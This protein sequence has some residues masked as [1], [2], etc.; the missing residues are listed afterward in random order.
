MM[1]D[2]VICCRMLTENLWYHLEQISVTPS[3]TK[4]FY[5]VKVLAPLKRVIGLIGRNSPGSMRE[6]PKMECAA[7]I[8][9]WDI[10]P[11]SNQ[12]FSSPPHAKHSGSVCSI[13]FVLW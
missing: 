3:Y 7:N 12:L 5:I 10:L 8:L 9:Y 2:R 13:C 6:A 4:P 11:E 1:Q